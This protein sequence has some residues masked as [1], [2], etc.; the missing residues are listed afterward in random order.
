MEIGRLVKQ[1][2]Y[3]P[4][5]IT[6]RIQ[7]QV[8]NA[9]SI[10][11]EVLVEKV[12]Q[13][14]PLSFVYCTVRGYRFKLPNANPYVIDDLPLTP[15]NNNMAQYMTQVVQAEIGTPR[16]CFFSYPPQ[17]IQWVQLSDADKPCFWYFEASIP[18]VPPAGTWFYPKS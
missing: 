14:L 2:S 8:S 6:V 9:L 17:P 13:E 4:L 11:T 18:G 16:I 5:R 15:E 1:W 10:S 7:E 12:A 3:A